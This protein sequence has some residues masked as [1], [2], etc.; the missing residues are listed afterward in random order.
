MK[1]PTCS[2]TLIITDRQSIEI[3]YCRKCKGVWLDRAEL[4]KII[5]KH[6]TTAAPGSNFNASKTGLHNNPFYKHKKQRGFLND[7]FDFD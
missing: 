1:C 4:D 6:S 3:N 5:E 7:M 2:E